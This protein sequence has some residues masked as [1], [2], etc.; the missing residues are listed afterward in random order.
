M[1][2][3]GITTTIKSA[4]L[5]QTIIEDNNIVINSLNEEARAIDENIDHLWQHV[6]EAEQKKDLSITVNT[7]SQSPQQSRAARA[8]ITSWIDKITATT[9]INNDKSVT[10]EML[11][12]DMLKTALIDRI[13]DLYLDQITLDRESEELAEQNRLYKNIA[14]FLQILG[15]MFVLAKDVFRAN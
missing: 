10:D 5:S 7:L 3:I 6:K 15:L 14:L 9:A 11:L 12:I 4:L 8:Y 2:L 13:N 1:V